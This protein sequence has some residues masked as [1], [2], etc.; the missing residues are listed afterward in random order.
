MKNKKSIRF[1]IKK[2]I[3]FSI[4]VSLS[5]NLVFLFLVPNFHHHNHY[6]HHNNHAENSQIEKCCSIVH[7]V[8]IGKSTHQA[9]NKKNASPND[10]PIEKFSENYTSLSI[11]TYLFINIFD[12]NIKKT[13]PYRIVII[14]YLDI[15]SSLQ[16]AP[17]PIL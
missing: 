5:V 3:R 14:K 13:K 7:D 11:S 12:T 1:L 15:L 4:V 16:R 2:T 17:P 10:C 8:N 9:K 6:S